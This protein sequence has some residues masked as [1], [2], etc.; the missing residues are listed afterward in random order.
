MNINLTINEMKV[1]LYSIQ[2]RI[3]LKLDQIIKYIEV[4]LN[5]GKIIIYD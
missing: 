4:C 1:V 2:G 3:I 5:T